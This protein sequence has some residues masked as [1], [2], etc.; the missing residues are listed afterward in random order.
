MSEKQA[1][2]ARLREALADAAT[3]H[4][5]L[6]VLREEGYTKD[7]LYEALSAL[8]TAGLKEEQEDVALEGMD[9]LVGHCGP[10][11]QIE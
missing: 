4:A 3:V 1:L 7:E 10:D 5:T 11:A 9:F 8:R 6:K 2:E